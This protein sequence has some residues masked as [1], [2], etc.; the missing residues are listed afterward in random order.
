MIGPLVDNATHTLCGLAL[1]RAG[2]DRG[3]PL[4]T[5][6][7]VA[8]ANLPDL[9]IVTMASQ[10][11]YLCHH[12]GITHAVLG[13]AV[14]A[15]LLAA[16]VVAI[17]R[18]EAG[19]RLPVL[20]AA[21]AGLGSHLLLDGLNTY[22][23]RPWLPFDQRWYYGDIAFIVDPWLWLCFFTAAALGTPPRED[24][25]PRQT[26][27]FLLF[28]TVAL[29]FMLAQSRADAGAIPVVWAV[30][31]SGLLAARRRGLGLARRH[32]LA[33]GAIAVALGYLAVL[34]G[35]SRA[36]EALARAEVAE[37][38][39]AAVEV[40]SVQ[41]EPASIRRFHAVVSTRETTWLL[42]VDLDRAEA[43]PW[44]ERPRNLDE[45]ALALVRDAPEHRAWRVFARHPFV[46]WTPDG[47]LLLGDARYAPEARPSWCN[48]AVPAATPTSGS[49]SRPSP[50]R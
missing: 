5:V 16:L 47:R 2:L 42:A 44:L 32:L 50:S 18:A 40:A 8:G 4:A 3:G 41:P 49:A 11:A 12:R 20:L 30:A 26:W 34:A 1:A 29:V 17:G 28:A 10:P 35:G 14:E 9:D 33:L 19:R 13:L 21:A 38:T 23:I 37:I 39:S 31:V 45:P 43:L 15:L 36:A 27:G 48:F 24:G 46:D 22:G 7:V 6:A 25:R